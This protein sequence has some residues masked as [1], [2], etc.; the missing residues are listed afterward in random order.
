M[1]NCGKFDNQFSIIKIMEALSID[2]LDEYL[3]MNISNY[4]DSTSLVSYINIYPQIKQIHKHFGSIYEIPK[5]KI[6]TVYCTIIVYDVDYTMMI[7]ALHS[8]K[9]YFGTSCIIK[10]IHYKN[11]LKIELFIYDLDKFISFFGIFYQLNRFLIQR[12]C[13]CMKISINDSIKNID[14]KHIY[15]DLGNNILIPLSIDI[16]TGKADI[17]MNTFLKN[18]NCPYIFC[19]GF[20]ESIK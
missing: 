9:R 2:L 14:S 16:K 8:I 10:K 7:R 6:N 3:Q 4:L 19:Q 1:L 13:F 20:C 18:I 15:L 11:T 17:D 5:N 12:S